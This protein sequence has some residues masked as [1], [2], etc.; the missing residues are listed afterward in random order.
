MSLIKWDDSLVSGPTVEPLDL[1][2]VKKQLRFTST[3]E[4]TL[5]DLWISMAR[6][7]FETRTGLSL[8]TQTH[9]RTLDA[10]PVSGLV[11]LPRRPLQAV[12]SISSDDGSPES[13]LAASSYRVYVPS[14][15]VPAPG[16]VDLRGGWSGTRG[17]IEYRAGFGD[18]PGAVPEL[19]RGALMLLVAN[20]HKYRSEVQDA[21]SAGKGGVEVPLGAEMIM[22]Q[23]R[24]K[25]RSV[26]PPMRTV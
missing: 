26:V 7:Y 23:Y 17:R 11:E 3:T 19:I 18:A 21:T 6:Q 2:E 1:D 22:R 15:D 24:Y 14:G 8:I 16:Y 9:A 13:V 10:M 25:G 20:F 12:V 4:D 5:L